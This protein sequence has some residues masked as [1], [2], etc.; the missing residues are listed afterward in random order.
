MTFDGE[1]HV[2]SVD[3]CS[4][5]VATTEEA[6]NG[7]RANVRGRSTNLGRL[8]EDSTLWYARQAFPDLGVDVALKNGG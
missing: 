5:P 7:K 8:A 6:L 4:G 3:P 2:I 1:G